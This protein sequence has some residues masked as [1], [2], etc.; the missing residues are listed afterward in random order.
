[1][2]IAYRVFVGLEFFRDSDLK[3]INKGTTAEKNEKALRI[4][5]NLDIGIWPMFIVRPEFERKDFA[6]LRRRCLGLDLDFIGFSVLT[7]LPG[8]GLY[9]DVKER[10][11][12]SNYDYFDFF[13]T[14]LPTKLPLGEFYRELIG[15]YKGSRSLKNQ[16][17]FMCKYP[18]R[19]LP[20]S[21]RTFNKFI[22][23]LKTLADDYL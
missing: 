1:M 19:E 18:L 3:S 5:K 13:H 21:L 22:K 9:E 20:G 23:R 8:T 6:D 12:T 16:I 10:L 11:I 4:L 2:D 15:L 14:Q 17:K 7:P